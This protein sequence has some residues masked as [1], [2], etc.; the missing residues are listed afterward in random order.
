MMGSVDLG[1]QQMLSVPYALHSSSSDN[2][3]NG[4]SN[5]STTGDT[6]YMAN[7]SFIIVPGISAA[8]FPPAVLGCT[9]NA[10]CNYNSEATQNDNSC[11]Y[12]N[13]T[14]NDNNV[15]T[16][17]DLINGSCECTGTAIV[18]GCTN[19]QACNYNSAANVDNGSCL[20]Q[21]SACN[22]N[23]PNTTNDVINGSCVCAGT[24]VSN[25]DLVI[26][27]NFQGGRV[28][29]I[30]QA[31]DVGYVPGEIHGLII[32]ISVIS[33]TASN[34]NNSWGNLIYGEFGCQG[35]LIGNTSSVQGSGV[36]NTNSILSGCASNLSA[37]YKCDVLVIDGYSDWFLPSK[38]E[39][40]I[41]YQNYQAVGG[42]YPSQS[43]GVW[44]SSE[45]N[46][47]NG[48]VCSFDGGGGWVSLPKSYV[49]AIKPLRRF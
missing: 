39:V 32:P 14:C 38:Q 45:I 3:A 41:I 48:W 43:Q 33:T 17:N 11:L 18:N 28:I 27:S 30:F 13:A 34:T 24:T 10:A 4:F 5:V 42:V 19:A 6:L 35:S 20:I 22:D 21:G 47:S 37:A 26:G 1:T 7:G 15:N 9:D 49:F 31:G 25:N 2:A 23:N 46:A 12:L 29:Y 40:S 16:I 44:S 36:S 8:N